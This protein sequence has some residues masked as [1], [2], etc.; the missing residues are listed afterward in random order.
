[1]NVVHLE[2]RKASRQDSGELLEVLMEVE[3]CHE[4]EGR[5]AS[6]LDRF[7]E[8]GLLISLQRPRSFKKA[9]SL[10][11]GDTICMYRPT[12]YTVL[13]KLYIAYFDV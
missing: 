2:S 9:I 6:V 10:D 7:R 12:K 13:G 5:L 4:G 3:H 11:K 1:M 8:R